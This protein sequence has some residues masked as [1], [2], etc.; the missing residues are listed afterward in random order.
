MKN[1][2]SVS[3]QSDKISV[4]MGIYNCENTLGE[5]ID[6]ILSQTYTN[7][8]LIM[9]DDASTDDTYY[10]ADEYRKRF[11]D[12]II[13]LRN[14]QNMRLSYTLNRCLKY[15]SGTYIARM[16]AD[17]LSVPER[18]E[19]QVKF[20]KQNS[21]IDLVGTAMQRF[22]QNGYADI[23][24]KL[25]FPDLYSMKNGTIFNHATIITYK[26]VY[27]A[28]NGYTVSNRTTRGQDY[29]LWFRFL[30]EGFTGANLGE[31]LYL[32][33]ED[34]S[35]VKRRTLKTRWNSYKTTLFGYKLLQ[36]PK[37]WY[38]KPTIQLFKCF[39]PPRFILIYRNIQKRRFSKLND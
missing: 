15:A 22:N 21:C 25:E 31:P 36:Y 10:V 9:C 20:L 34:L 30:Y 11:P 38:I 5:A 23:D 1:S 29:D 7:W 35:A 17:D 2:E 26:K 8:E 12:K 16:D 3:R 6:S 24:Y 4:V 28:L 18:F 39:I 32:V 19:K 14:D 33:R 27:D 13:L 37:I